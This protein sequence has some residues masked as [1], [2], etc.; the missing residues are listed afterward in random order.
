VFF[1][2]LFFG[3]ILAGISYCGYGVYRR[4]V[5]TEAQNETSLG[6]DLVN[7]EDKTK[8]QMAF[9]HF[10]KA[11]SLD[12]SLDSAI[13]GLG[14][15]YYNK[16]KD[17]DNKK[18]ET[19]FRHALDVN[20]RSG[21]AKLWLARLQVRRKDLEGALNLYTEAVDA[22]EPKIALKEKI[23]ILMD[24][25]DLHWS[26]VSERYRLANEA[27]KDITRLLLLSPNEP[28]LYTYRSSAYAALGRKAESDADHNKSK[29]VTNPN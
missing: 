3:S 10:T 29:I 7:D 13:I 24:Q 5:P 4:F 16:E 15:Y 6:W 17:E 8:V 9:A 12:P 18:A 21:L 19:L 2:T 22:G 14:V 28:L 20:P 25:I 11:L 23:E 26:E 1:F 27:I